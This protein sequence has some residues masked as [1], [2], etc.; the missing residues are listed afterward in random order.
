MKT[1][2]KTGFLLTFAFAGC[3]GA[4]ATKTTITDSIAKPQQEQIE[5]KK[6]ALADTQS[7]VSAWLQ[8]LVDSYFHYT[9][10]E[11]IRDQVD[12]NGDTSEAWIIDDLVITDTASYLTLH[13]GHGEAEADGSEPRYATDG[14]IYVDTITKT[15]YEYGANGTLRKWI[16]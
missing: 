12:S 3:N 9:K 10:N 4:P 15:I 11:L 7:S 8:P 6:V 13:I 16:R 5:K 1:L 2:L 14:W